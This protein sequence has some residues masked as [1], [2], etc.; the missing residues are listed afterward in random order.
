MIAHGALLGR[1]RALDDGSAVAA[2]PLVLADAHPDLAGLDILRE[3]AVAFLVMRL[4]L[5][6]L[7]ELEG[8]VGEALGRGL[9]SHAG[10][11]V[12]RSVM[13]ER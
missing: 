1:F 4:D 2:L 3:L 12:G 6:D 10:V 11:Y 9:V 7:A 5:R 8:D 13:G